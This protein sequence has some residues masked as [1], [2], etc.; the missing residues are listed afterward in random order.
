MLPETPDSS[1][2]DVSLPLQ[3]GCACGAVRYTL[4]SAPVALFACHCT[5]CQRQS[6]SAFG[7][8]LRVRR[9]D[10][11]IQGETVTLRRETERGTRSES[12]FCPGCGG[13][14]YNMRPGT[15]YCHLRGGTLDDTSWL[16]PA[17]HIWTRH[18]QPWFTPPA[19]TLVETG[20]PASLDAIVQHWQ[21]TKAPRFR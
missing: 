12:V 3:G 10:L 15:D 11:D 16:R 21:D 7:Q 8:S 17:A 18:A 13:R 5:L 6:G 4:K 20:Q 19:D 2:P 9:A 14:L 1:R